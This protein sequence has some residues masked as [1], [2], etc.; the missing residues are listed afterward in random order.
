MQVYVDATLL[1][2]YDILNNDPIVL[3]KS[4][5]SREIILAWN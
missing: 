4:I 5:D 1:Y 3:V 2:S